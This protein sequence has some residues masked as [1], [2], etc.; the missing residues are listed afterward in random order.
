[1]NI[2]KRKKYD[3]CKS[4]PLPLSKKYFEELTHALIGCIKVLS[5][6]P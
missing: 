1:M 5:S 2:K 4:T 3:K 6:I